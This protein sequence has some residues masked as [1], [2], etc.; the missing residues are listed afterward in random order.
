[1]QLIKQVASVASD[2]IG[3]IEDGLA[4]GSG[5]SWLSGPHKNECVMYVAHAESLQKDLAELEFSCI[6]IVKPSSDSK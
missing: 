1:V 2:A 6:N 4:G 5:C 3:G